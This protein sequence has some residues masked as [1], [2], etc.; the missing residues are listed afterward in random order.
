M[1]ACRPDVGRLRPDQSAIAKLFQAVRRPAE[2]ATD[3][4]SG[5]EQLGRQSQTVQQQ[6]RVGLDVG[7]EAAARL[8]FAQQAQR[9]GFDRPGKVVEQS[10]AVTRVEALGGLD[11]DVGAPIA[12][13]IDAVSEP[14]EALT[15]I[16]HGADDRFRALGR[17]DLE[18]HVERRTRGPLGAHRRELDQI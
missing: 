4:K 13:S 9:R 11:H 18:H 17:A 10:I 1:K 3:G 16:Q 7:V 5:R 6:G 15:A 12:Y 14:H 2:D 8:A